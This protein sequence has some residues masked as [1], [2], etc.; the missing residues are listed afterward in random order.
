[1][2]GTYQRPQKDSVRHN[3]FEHIGRLSPKRH[4]SILTLP[5]REALCSHKLHQMGMIGHK[6]HQIWV[7]NDVARRPYL[8]FERTKFRGEIDVRIGDLEDVKLNR[9]LDLVNADMESSLTRRLSIWLSDELGPHLVPGADFIGTFTQWSRN[10]ALY[11]WLKENKDDC[12]LTPHLRK[13]MIQHGTIEPRV[14]FPLALLLSSLQIEVNGTIATFEYGDGRAKMIS[15]VIP[16]IHRGVSDWPTIKEVLAEADLG[17]RS[18]EKSKKH[19]KDLEGKVVAA[20][21]TMMMV[22][23]REDN[24]WWVARKGAR[25]TK[26]KPYATLEEIVA[27]WQFSV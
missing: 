2:S 6:T 24:Q 7:E 12:V 27:E 21:E 19:E 14:I 23:L 3:S 16:N 10:N 9:S 20:L 25:V 17:K 26:I 15:I 5:S 22:L 4:L 11:E 18:F 8:D 13:L 1:M